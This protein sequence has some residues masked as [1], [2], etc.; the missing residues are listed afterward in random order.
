MQDHM[1]AAEYRR[2]F[3]DSVDEAENPYEGYFLKALE[4]TRDKLYSSKGSLTIPKLEKLERKHEEDDLTI[5]VTDYLEVLKLQGKIVLFSHIPQETYTK[6]WST[7]R[8]NTAMGVRAGVPDMLIVYHNHILFLELK[9]AKGGVV[10]EDQQKWINA[11]NEV[12]PLSYPTVFAQVACGWDQAKE[13]I[14]SLMND[15]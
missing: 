10:S 12:N 15:L 8:K 9:R 11:I 13:A 14:D 5:Q 6:S 3:V 1:S 4:K 2:Q 7:K